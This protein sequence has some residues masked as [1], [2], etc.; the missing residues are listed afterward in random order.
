MGQSRTKAEIKYFF[1]T[2]RNMEIKFHQSLLEFQETEV[3]VQHMNLMY[4]IYLVQYD[5]KQNQ[6]H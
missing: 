5:S 6:F 3:R 2:Q 4:R 1:K